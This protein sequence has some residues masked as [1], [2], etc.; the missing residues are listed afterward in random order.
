MRHEIQLLLILNK[1]KQK[2]INPST[3]VDDKTMQKINI[4]HRLRATNDV[5]KCH[6][7]SVIETTDVE[8]YRILLWC[9]KTQNSS[10][11]TSVIITTDVEGYIILLRFWQN[12]MQKVRHSTSVLGTTDVEW[13]T[14]IDILH[15]FFA[16]NRCRVSYFL[17]R[18]LLITDV[19]C[20]TFY[21]SQMT[22]VERRET[23]NIV[24]YDDA[25]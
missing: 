19:E 7:T 16:N 25:S 9:P 24:C 23:F 1:K 22:D 20:L 8:Q 5:E 21:I 17:H 6:S 11:S 2:K 10:Y 18:F 13:L 12:T 4:Q 14:K 15:R 3:S